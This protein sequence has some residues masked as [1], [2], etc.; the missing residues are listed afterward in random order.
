MAMSDI[1]MPATGASF[2]AIFDL[3]DWDRS[4]AQ[5]APGQAGSPASAHAADVSKLW[6][7]GEYFPLVFSDAA[8]R[9]NAEATLALVPVRLKPSLGE[10]GTP[11]ACRRADTTDGQRSTQRTR[12][13]IDTLRTVRA[14]R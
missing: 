7:A 6:A 4:V 12:R 13:E 11:W 3:A 1:G 14:L 10:L 9:A 2:R 5:N 8:V